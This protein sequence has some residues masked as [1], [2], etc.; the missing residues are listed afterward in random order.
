MTHI[1]FISSLRKQTQVDFPIFRNQ[2]VR[3]RKI[4]SSIKSPANAS[5][6]VRGRGKSCDCLRWLLLIAFHH[7]PQVQHSSLH[8]FQ[9]I[10]SI[11]ATNS[12]QV[13]I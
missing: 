12:K 13:H 5:W 8:L 10:I 9:K 6:T 4:F 1:S 3:L 2:K 11:K 7:A